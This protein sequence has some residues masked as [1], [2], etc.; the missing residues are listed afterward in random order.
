MHEGLKNRVSYINDL[1][2]KLNH[3]KYSLHHSASEING[4]LLQALDERDYLI[5]A[6]SELDNESKQIPSNEEENILV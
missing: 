4:Q 6:L 1:I 2:K 5:L 3:K